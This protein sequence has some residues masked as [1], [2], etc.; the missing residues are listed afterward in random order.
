M[1]VSNYLRKNRKSLRKNRKSLRKNRKSLRKNRKSLRKNRKSLRGGM[2]GDLFSVYATDGVADDGE[3]TLSSQINSNFKPK[4]GGI[5]G[6]LFD[7]VYGKKEVADGE[8]HSPN[9]SSKLKNNIVGMENKKNLVARPTSKEKEDSTATEAKKRCLIIQDIKKWD[10]ITKPCKTHDVDVKKKAWR[11]LAVKYHPDK[12]K[13]CVDE[14]TELFKKIN[15]DCNKGSPSEHTRYRSSA[16]A[17]YTDITEWDDILDWREKAVYWYIRNKHSNP[18]DPTG[19]YLADIARLQAKSWRSMDSLAL[20]TSTTSLLNFSTKGEGPHSVLTEN[21]APVEI[22]APR[23]F[24]V[25][26]SIPPLSKFSDTMILS[27]LEKIDPNFKKIFSE[28][29]RY[30]KPFVKTPGSTKPTKEEKKAVFKQLEENTKYFDYVDDEDL[31]PD[32]IVK[33]TD[34][35]EDSNEYLGKINYSETDVRTNVYINFEGMDGIGKKV[36]PDKNYTTVYLINKNN[37]GEIHGTKTE[38]DTLYTVYQKQGKVDEDYEP[39]HILETK[40]TAINYLCQALR[41]VHNKMSVTPNFS[42]DMV[43]PTNFNEPESD[44]VTKA[45]VILNGLKTQEGLPFEPDTTKIPAVKY[46]VKSTYN[47]KTEE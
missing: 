34:S 4:F 43:L 6:K 19:D 13:S 25:I 18:G 36:F 33:N 44:D 5:F 40:Y 47:D 22:N 31:P 12:N 20:R 15:E 46:Y 37:I 41:N 3:I 39:Y 17:T 16:Q 14:A 23:P 21:G 42:D 29:P 2:F 27:S 38:I 26:A 30:E 10:G 1:G 7:L 9:V 32:V 45:F 11:N 28:Y 35:K 24:P 8:I